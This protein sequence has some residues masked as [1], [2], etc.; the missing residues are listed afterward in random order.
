MKKI[1][2]LKEQLF[3]DL[4]ILDKSI[5]VLQYSLKKAQIISI[6]DE[7][8]YDELEVFEALEG[9]YSRSSDILTQKLIKNMFMIMQEESRTF[10]DRCNLCEKL[11]IVTSS[12]DLYN[13]RRLRNDIAHEYCIVDITEIF[14]SLLEY[15]D[16]L[17]ENISKT[18]I[19]IENNLS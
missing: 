12:D 6:K 14:E 2:L 9:R 17:L 5:E 4:S 13:I 7:Y 11:D 10:I 16:L 15:S 3:F 18:K 19:Y 1:N 8:T